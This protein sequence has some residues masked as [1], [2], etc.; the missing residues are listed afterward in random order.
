[1]IKET[2]TKERINAEL[3]KKNKHGAGG[4]V[5]LFLLLFFFFLIFAVPFLI[6]FQIFGI[7]LLINLGLSLTITII[8]QAHANKVYNL[9][10]KYKYKIAEDK[11][12]G[13]TEKIGHSHGKQYYKPFE[14]H[15]ASYGD[16]KIYDTETFYKWS[17][18]IQLGDDGFLHTSDPGDMFYIITLDDKKILYI[19]P[20]KFFELK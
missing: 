20:Q 8:H 2:I 19:Y 3:L 6:N 16:F 11:L 9:I 7:I 12:V 1:M 10:K 17:E 5:M 13:Y 14:L 15:F 18:N 4:F